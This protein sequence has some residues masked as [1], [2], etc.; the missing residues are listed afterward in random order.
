[1]DLVARPTKS[2]AARIGFAEGTFNNMR[3]Y[4][5]GPPYVKAGRKVLYRDVDVDAWLARKI[6]FST[7]QPVPA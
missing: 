4:G 2:A 7:S 5:G 1:M 3:V 6:I